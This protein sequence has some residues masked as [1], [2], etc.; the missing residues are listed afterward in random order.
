MTRTPTNHSWVSKLKHS[1]LLSPLSNANWLC[2]SHHFESFT[3]ATITWLTVY[4]I[5]VTHDH[6]YIPLVVSTSRSFPHSW[7][8]TGF[9]TRLT[10]RVPH[11]EQE[12][13][14]L[15][16]HTSSPPVFSGVRV[17]R[18]LVWCVCFVDRCLSLCTFSF[19]HCV[20]CSS[21]IYWFW[22]YLW[23]PQT[24]L[25]TNVNGGSPFQLSFATFDIIFNL[26]KVVGRRIKSKN[27]QHV[28]NVE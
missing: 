17:I 19:D 25:M 13:P 3:V 24:L 8:I 10:R 26:L 27:R 21:L 14:T 4:N 7:L 12:L 15:P 16:E 2:W 6:G 5:C 1:M 18:S 20:V 9:A 28:R 23:Y 11:K 22:L